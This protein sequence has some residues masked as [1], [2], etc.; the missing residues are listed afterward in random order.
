MH[1]RV[2]S[3]PGT[4]LRLLCSWFLTVMLLWAGRD[5]WALDRFQVEGYLLPNGLQLLLKPG[6]ERGHVSIR[7]VVGVGFDDFSCTDQE[8]PHLL[9][10]L[11]FS[12]I[13]ER[14]EGGLEEQMQA[15]GGE[16]NAFTSSADT[17][18]VIEAPARN[19]RQVLDLLLAALTQTPID[20]NALESA[21]RI[22]ERE[23]GGHHSHLQR[24]LDKQPQDSNASSQLA[25]ELGLKCPERP[26]VADLTLEQVHDVR[27]NWYA[28]NN[29]SLIVVGGLD[30]LLP[31]YL[32]RT[33]GALAAVEPS[34]HQDLRSVTHEAEAQ[35][36]LTRG[37][38]GDGAKVHLYFLEP[39]LETAHPA[40][41][42]LLQSYLDWELYRELRLTHGLSYGPWVA[43]ESY[44]DSG[45]LSLNAD[46]DQADLGETGLVLGQMIQRLRDDGVD[47]ATFKRLKG[48]AIARQGWAAQGNIALAD[49][50]WG[51]LADYADGRFSNPA[52]QLGQVTLEDANTALR[53]LLSTPGYT[54]I[55]KPLLSYDELYQL[56]CAVLIAL[57]LLLLGLMAWRRR[58]RKR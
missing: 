39:V 18:F 38:L 28:P 48:L 46:V 10:H 55:E 15:L 45:L 49:Y 30:K 40:T 27:Q 57:V 54:R 9:E 24:L 44:G 35:R 51:A 25:I 5:A 50:Y 29:M 32:E 23:D 20:E 2:K 42:D 53:Q 14:G 11:L 17:T 6:D 3:A 41:L 33:W 13:D 36:E 56:A 12:G 31:A 22:V 26:E 16:W 52:R 58:A 43:R 21:K 1:E 37:W 19:Q 8:L 47:A 34:D 4:H 7:L